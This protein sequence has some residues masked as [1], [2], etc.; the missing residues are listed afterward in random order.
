MGPESA[1]RA[2]P[3]ENANLLISKLL[4]IISLAGHR[5]ND[6]GS[7]KTKMPW[8]AM[9]PWDYRALS[10]ATERSRYHLSDLTVTTQIPS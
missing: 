1:T 4:W 10:L 5:V 3:G 8:R 6:P 9:T 7:S 2:K